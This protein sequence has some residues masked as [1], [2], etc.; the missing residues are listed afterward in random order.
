MTNS[1]FER[2]LGAF[3]LGGA[4]ALAGA[5]AIWTFWGC[6]TPPDRIQLTLRDASAVRT[7]ADVSA[8]DVAG[9]QGY[10]VCVCPSCGTTVTQLGQVK[11]INVLCPACG[12]PMV[13]PGSVFAWR[14]LVFRPLVIASLI[15]VMLALAAHYLI[16]GPKRLPGAG[17]ATVKR[18]SAFETAWHFVV[19]VSFGILAVTGLA[20]II[21][22]GANISGSVGG[23]FFLILHYIAAAGFTAGL[24]V[25]GG[26]WLH[27]C[28][29]DRG[30]RTWL[31]HAGGYFG[32]KGELPAG[33]FNPGQKA[34]FWLVCVLGVVMIVTGLIRLFP[35]FTRQVQQAAYMI[36]DVVALLLLLGVLVH[37]YLGTVANPGSWQ[38]IFAG[39]VT[40]EWAKAHHSTWEYEVETP[41][42]RPS[43]VAAQA[44]PAEEGL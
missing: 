27:D 33:R 17:T 41:S 26:L 7:A 34:F 31:R 29:F 43:A 20:G 37:A 1:V 36:H 30:D 8:A 32:Y 14:E 2:S 39:R 19:L 24:V 5:V 25:I 10:S 22:P 18:F 9:K 23:D 11:C 12:S 21:G 38:A 15:A 16:W 13:S 44:F 28:F 4:C 40:E 3:L 42:T 6:L 35:V